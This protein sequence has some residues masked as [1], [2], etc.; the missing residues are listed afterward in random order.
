[1]ATQADRRRQQNTAPP[2][3]Q[4]SQKIQGQ[5]A[6]PEFGGTLPNGAPAG[7][8]A[9]AHP[10]TP[11]YKPPQGPTLPPGGVGGPVFPDSGVAPVAY[12]G[13]FFNPTTAPYG[14]DMSMPGVGEQFW[15][16]NQNLWFQSPQLDWVDSQLPQ[17]QN[18]WQGEQANQELLGNIRNP[19]PGQQFWDGVKGNFNTMSGAER[20]VAAGY[21]GPNHAAEA[22]RMTKGRMPQSFQPQF[23]AYYD[24]M[25]DKVM[26]DVNS[27]AAARGSYGGSA[28]LNGSIGAGL[29]VE[30]QRAKAAT[31]FMFQDSANQL[32]WLNTIGSQGRA[33]DLSGQG[34]YGLNIA[35]AQQGLDK[36]K[37]YGDLA[38]AAE[39]MDFAKDKAYSDIAF[40]LD[41]QALERLG[42]GIST[43]FNSH[44]AHRGQLEG[45]FDAANVVQD[46]RE[47]RIGSLYDDLSG[48]S[49][50]TV[51]FLMNNFDA[52]LGGDQA[53]TSEQLQTMI[54]QAAQQQGWDS[55]TQ[56]RIFRDLEGIIDAATGAKE[57]GMI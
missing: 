44:Q 38:F 18:P 19:G 34:A 13:G 48:F 5:P 22:Y 49:N 31:D 29:D 2:T 40:G 54:A 1:M 7:D 4:P 37:T 21:N 10:N 15:N 36:V 35:G 42:A 12:N 56:E 28:A 23:D 50:D 9:Y 39:G 8:P 24:R 33:A 52:L 14:F 32:N 26:S 51:N 16:N 27:Q 25:K 43:A 55:R 57:A 6:V 20:N 41:D 46:Q 3:A 53:M 30:A 11:N 45:A 47:G 17:F